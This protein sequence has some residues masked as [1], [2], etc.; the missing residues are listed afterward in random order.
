MKKDLVEGE[1]FYLSEMGFRIFTEKY[2]L[3][4]GFCCM[5]GCKHCPYGFNKLIG[6][7]RKKTKTMTFKEEILQGIPDVLPT[8]PAYDTTINHAPKRKEILTDEE[9]NLALR[10]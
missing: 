1:D 6:Q 10:N 8:P 9:K 7:I 2:L 4:R 5:S 3:E